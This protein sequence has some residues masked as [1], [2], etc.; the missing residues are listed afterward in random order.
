MNKLDMLDSIKEFIQQNKPSEL[1][2][3]VLSLKNIQLTCSEIT[4]LLK[5]LSPN[6]PAYKYYLLSGSGGSGI[7]KPNITSIASIYLSVMG[8]PIIKV[9]SKKMSGLWGSS[10]FFKDFSFDDVNQNL[11]VFDVNDFSPWVK[12]TNILNIHPDFKNYFE[13]YYYNVFCAKGKLVGISDVARSNI[14]LKKQQ[15]NQPKQLFVCYTETSQGTL[16]E[17]APGKIFINNNLFIETETVMFE[18]INLN[19][20]K[21]L[22]FKLLSATCEK[23]FWYFCLEYTVSVFLFKFGFVSSF[24]EGKL[25]FQEAYKNKIVLDTMD[26]IE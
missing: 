23:N 8:I 11:I 22:N 6:I 14:Y 17:L 9:G 4:K 12:F 18:H 2:D 3:A 26:L 1:F 25:I 7:Y 24:S 19:Q 10:D 13:A 16:D 5:E 21:L 15:I 20:L